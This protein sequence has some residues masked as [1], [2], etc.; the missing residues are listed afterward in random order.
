MFRVVLQCI[1]LTSMLLVGFSNCLYAQT[2]KVRIEGIRAPE[3]TIRLGF[4]NSEAQWKTEKSNFQRAQG[5]GQ[6]RNGVLEFTFKD[7]LPGEYAVAIADD[8]NDNGEMDWGWLL[9]KEGFGFSNYEL[10]GVRR[11]QY[12]DFK[13]NFLPEGVTEIIIK[14]RYL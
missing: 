2:L 1:I 5:K 10:T 12:P 11:P 7:I 14:V 9:P 6:L 8:E 4:Y 13:F 3:G